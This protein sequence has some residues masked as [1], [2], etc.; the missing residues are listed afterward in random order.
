MMGPLMMMT[1]MNKPNNKNEGAENSAL[2]ESLKKNNEMIL[3]LNSGGYAG[4]SRENENNL[5]MNRLHELEEKLASK[6]SKSSQ[7]GG[8]M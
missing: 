6:Y 3:A 8:G 7:G 5:L 4:Q 2:M 1:M